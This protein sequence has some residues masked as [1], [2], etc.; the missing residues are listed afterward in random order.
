MESGKQAHYYNMSD[1]KN[2]TGKDDG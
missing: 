1:K 2:L